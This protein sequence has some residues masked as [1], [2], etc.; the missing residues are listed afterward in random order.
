MPYFGGS[1]GTSTPG[2]PGAP[3]NP[4]FITT[5]NLAAPP[6]AARAGDIIV[7]TGMANITIGNLAALPPGAVVMITSLSPFT[8]AAAGNIRGPAGLQGIQGLT[9]ATGSTGPEGPAGG[10]VD[11]SGGLR[12]TWLDVGHAAQSYRSP[13]S[14]YMDCLDVQYGGSRFGRSGGYGSTDYFY[15]PVNFQNSV[16]IGNAYGLAASYLT[17]GTQGSYGSSSYFYNNSYFEGAL[18]SR[19]GTHL[20]YGMTVYG[21]SGSTEVFGFTY[22]G[23]S[24][25]PRAHNGIL[26]GYG[27]NGA[28]HNAY[29]YVYGS[30]AATALLPATTTRFSA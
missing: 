27:S 2:A 4:P 16:T 17:I 23:S 24:S 19:M 21:D 6:A 7:N 14:A 1:G 13:G 20:Y 8:V 26:L 10:G 28:N 25:M 3:G 30:S 5:V 9:G 11:P 22:G 29:S 12:G 15:N 18:I